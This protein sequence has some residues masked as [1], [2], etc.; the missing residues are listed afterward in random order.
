MI[1]GRELELGLA[2]ESTRGTAEVTPSRWVKNVSA[3]VVPKVEKIQDDNKRGLLE[4]HDGG[5]VVQ[6]WYEG[7]LEG[8]LHA[9][10]VG[11]LFYQL[12]G[13][14]SSVNV[15]GSVYSH[16]FTLEEEITHP[17][18][19]F[20]VKDGSVEQKKLNGGVISSLEVSATVNDYVRF[21]ANCIALDGV[22]DTSVPSYS[23]EYD[24][25]GKDVSIKIADTEV[26]LATAPA[27]KAKNITIKFNAETLRNHI[28][29]QYTPDA[30][31]NANFDIEIE[32]TK[33]YEDTTYETLFEA[34][35]YKY[36]QVSIIGEADLTGGNPTIILLLNRAQITAWDRNGGTDESVN[37]PFT[38]KAFYN[39]TDE[40]MSELT[41][42][43]LTSA[44]STE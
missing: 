40:Q 28:L 27:L 44:Y 18:L 15:S 29:G 3:N 38:I 12:Y 13:T 5:R 30:N 6:K 42:I 41:L 16:G 25:I 35:T 2:V 20:F 24:F 7:N 1:I 9:D 43:N 31:Y 4:K 21:T 11:Y 39:N 8:V 10:A 26:G 23:T 22:V 17:A 36:V 19:T 32:V 37:E 34:D 33:D 14:V